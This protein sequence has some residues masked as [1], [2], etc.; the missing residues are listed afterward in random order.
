[1]TDARTVPFKATF[2]SESEEL[3]M[4]EALR[5]LGILLSG[6]LLSEVRSSSG[7]IST[8]SRPKSTAEVPVAGSVRRLGCVTFTCIGTLPNT[9]RQ[10]RL[11]DLSII[12]FRPF[13]IYREG[14]SMDTWP[15]RDE[16]P[17]E[18]RAAFTSLVTNAGGALETEADFSS[19]FIIG[20]ATK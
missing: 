20:Q 14:E 19:P 16:M 1:M 4:E 2:P 10:T 18:W 6:L 12:W 11:R 17:G 15:D 13:A 7:N 8:Q 3:K 9:R 5:S